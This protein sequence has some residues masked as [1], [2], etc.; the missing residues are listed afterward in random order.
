MTKDEEEEA[1]RRKEEAEQ[2]QRES[3]SISRRDVDMATPI[4][5]L[6]NSMKK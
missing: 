3:S 1:I 5:I 6:E 4:D 2:K